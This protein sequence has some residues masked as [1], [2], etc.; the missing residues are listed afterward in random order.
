VN[1]RIY[2]DVGEILDTAT[3]E[4]TTFTISTPRRFLAAASVG[5]WAAFAGGSNLYA[6]YCLRLGSLTCTCSTHQFADVDLF[7]F[8]PEGG[9]TLQVEAPPTPTASVKQEL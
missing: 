2:L 6:A 1:L 7:Y 9:E 4:W 8:G 3:M 5:H